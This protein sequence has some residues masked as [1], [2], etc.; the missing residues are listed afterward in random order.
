ML[1][2]YLIDTLSIHKQTT[3]VN[4][5][6]ISIRK[7][8]IKMPMRK[9]DNDNGVIF[10]MNKMAESPQA[11]RK[12]QQKVYNSKSYK[13]PEAQRAVH[14]K[15]WQNTR[16][17]IIVADGGECQRCRIIF[18]RHESND[19]QVHHIKP[20]T[21]FPELTFVN[22]NLI[23]L[24]RICNLTLG[25]NGLDFDWTPEMRFR[26]VDEEIHI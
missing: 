15:R 21:Q 13:D 22:D 12:R 5:T 18:N 25:E 20:R 23:T 16:R 2:I 3:P 14:T 7:V 26:E 4:H 10:D 6:T 17:E 11:K 19:L 1:K 24:C 9:L 8:V